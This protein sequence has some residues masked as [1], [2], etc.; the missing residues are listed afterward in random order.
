VRSLGLHIHN[1]G[2]SLA[3]AVIHKSNHV[4]S[5]SL[6]AVWRL[7]G[8]AMSPGC[9]AIKQD[10]TDNAPNGGRIAAA[11]SCAINWENLA[12]FVIFVANAKEF[13]NLYLH[14]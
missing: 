2:V 6:G 13:F 12:V 5:N 11:L 3:R 4:E 14:S 8:G 1:E 9:M 10:A 7:E